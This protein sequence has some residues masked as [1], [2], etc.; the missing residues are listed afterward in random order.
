VFHSEGILLM[1]IL[2]CVVERWQPWHT[3]LFIS[4]DYVILLFSHIFIALCL[5]TLT[6]A[7]SKGSG[8]FLLCNVLNSV[9]LFTYSVAFS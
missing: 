8:M 3:P 9:C 7:E 1:Y 6:S 4:I 2:N 5:Y